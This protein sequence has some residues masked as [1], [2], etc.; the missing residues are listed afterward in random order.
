MC[1]SDGR[2]PNQ[3][4]LFGLKSKILHLTHNVL[5]E[6]LK[7]CFLCLTFSRYHRTR[8]TSSC[9]NPPL[10]AN[11]YQWIPFHSRVANSV[12]RTLTVLEISNGFDVRQED[13]LVQWSPRHN[14]F[15]YN[16]VFGSDVVR[17]EDLCC[18]KNSLSLLEYSTSCRKCAS[19]PSLAQ[20]FMPSGL[21]SWDTGS[22]RSHRK[23]TSNDWLASPK[24]LVLIKVACGFRIHAISFRGRAVIETWQ[25]T[26]ATLC[27]LKTDCGCLK[28]KRQG[29]AS[30]ED[31]SPFTRARDS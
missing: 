5:R 8:Y 28:R 7:F 14:A 24:L 10:S 1:F 19:F 27:Q 22:E 3:S 23:H 21:L 16:N 4:A 15:T 25:P 12:A 20:L 17:S 9:P 29:C 13:S 30:G 18:N 31:S 11:L 6:R 2:G 26:P